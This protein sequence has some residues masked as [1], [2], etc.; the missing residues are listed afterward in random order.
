MKDMLSLCIER[1]FG[2][3][4]GCMI[5]EIFFCKLV[6]MILVRSTGGWGLFKRKRGLTLFYSCRRLGHL[7]KECPGRG[8]SFLCCKSVDHE[9]LDFSRMIAKVE[10]INTK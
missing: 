3:T 5:P 2:L 10:K 6:T 1:M 9:V 4:N 8:P 7:A